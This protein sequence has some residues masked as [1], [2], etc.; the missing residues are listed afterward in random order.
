MKLGTDAIERIIRLHREGNSSVQI[1]R[2][3]GVEK[4]TVLRHLHRAGFELSR[5]FWTDEQLQI[6]RANEGLMP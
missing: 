4:S 2:M 5:D 6:V 1:A 3:V